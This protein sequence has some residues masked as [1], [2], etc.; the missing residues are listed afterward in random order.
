MAL[1]LLLWVLLLFSASLFV[2]GASGT[3]PLAAGC[4]PLDVA[5][6]SVETVQ[7]AIVGLIAPHLFPLIAFLV[8]LLVLPKAGWRGVVLSVVVIGGLVLY[9]IGVPGYVSPLRD[10]IF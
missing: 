9:Y 4:D 7:N 3:S 5:C 1:R 6:R 2:I 10:V 8:A